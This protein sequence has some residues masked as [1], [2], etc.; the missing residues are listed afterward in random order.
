[1]TFTW[2]GFGLCEV[3]TPLDRE[4]TYNIGDLLEDDQLPAGGGIIVEIQFESKG[5]LVLSTC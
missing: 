3:T 4:N 1:M 2:G 5:I